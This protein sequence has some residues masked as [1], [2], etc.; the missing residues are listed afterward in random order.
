MK[1]SGLSYLASPSSS[2]SSAWFE[3]TSE[4]GRRSSGSVRKLGPAEGGEGDHWFG[5]DVLRSFRWI[6]TTRLTVDSVTIDV[7]SI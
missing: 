6:F 3:L 4:L 7:V 2:T 1:G 5:Q